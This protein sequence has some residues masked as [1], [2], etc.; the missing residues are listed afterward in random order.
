MNNFDVKGF[1]QAARSQGYSDSVIRSHLEQRGVTQAQPTAQPTQTGFAATTPQFQTGIEPEIQEQKT[2]FRDRARETFERRGDIALE[3][4]EAPG[5][6]FRKGVRFA[7]QTAAAGFDILGL[8]L[9]AAVR[10]GGKVLDIATAPSRGAAKVVGVDVPKPTEAIKS[11]GLSILRSPV[12]Q[13]GLEALEGGVEKYQAWKE[14]N[15]GAAADLEAVVNIAFVMPV[16][17]GVRAAAGSTQ[18]A[19]APVIRTG[20][21]LTKSAVAAEKT[22]T[23]GA[24]A[25]LVS[26]VLKKTKLPEGR[27]LRDIKEGGIVAQRQ[28]AMES[29]IDKAVIKT[30]SGIPGIQKGSVLQ[31]G[32]T[33]ERYIETQ[34]K[35][36]T[37]LT[38]TKDVIF[39]KKE[40]IAKLNSTAAELAK[41]PLLTGDAGRSAKRV[42]DEYVRRINAS[43]GKLSEVLKIRKDMDS[44]VRKF[45]GDKV[46]SGEKANAM[47]LA[48]RQLR[49]TT[50]EY[51]ISRSPVGSQIQKSLRRQHHTFKALDNVQVKALKEAGSRLE[52]GLDVLGSALGTRSRVVQGLALASGIGTFGAMTVFAP[53]AS[54]GIG[55]AVAMR[56]LYRAAVSPSARRQLG[57]MLKGVGAAVSKLPTS[58]RTVGKDLVE[59]LIGMGVI[60]SREAYL[61]Y[62]IDETDR[63]QQS[64]EGM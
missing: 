8:G 58:E 50:N 36:L 61:P 13:K 44:W 2:T 24:V 11:A 45:A 32:Q 41:T 64:Q 46:L 30:V 54:V 29:T 9:G 28:F 43:K 27:T 40:L 17:T 21:R 51:L 3:S 60:T 23:T 56:T 38:K 19:A 57:E 31:K 47:G 62:E 39:P 1:I 6:I 7:G 26:P 33:M 42:I 20:E 63:E 35:A 49:N 5:G 10:G 14:E 37:R 59:L 15:P 22:A 25:N 53:V 34:A 52:R 12:G 4:M 16:G 18:R 55:G 48:V